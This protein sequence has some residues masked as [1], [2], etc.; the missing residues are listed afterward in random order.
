MENFKMIFNNSFFIF[1]LY[2]ISGFLSNVQA[3]KH[4]YSVYVENGPLD[5][6]LVNKVSQ[7]HLEHFFGRCYFYLLKNAY[8]YVYA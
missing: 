8:V 4:I 7:D 1:I 5:Y 3:I 6:L 2:Y